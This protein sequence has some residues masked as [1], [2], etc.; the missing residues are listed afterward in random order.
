MSEII[1]GASAGEIAGLAGGV[2]GKAVDLIQKL[3]DYAYK[4]LMK[5]AEW[6]KQA[7]MYYVDL[8]GK[9]PFDAL[10]LTLILAYW[11]SPL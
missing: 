2:L 3:G 11:I 1:A 5:L 10:A 4:I 8:W 9:R 6:V 7:V